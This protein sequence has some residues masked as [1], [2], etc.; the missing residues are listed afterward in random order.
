[1]LLRA[2]ASGSSSPGTSVSRVC[3]QW[4]H[5][6]GRTVQNDCGRTCVLR[7]RDEVSDEGGV[8]D[9]SVT[10]EERLRTVLGRGPTGGQPLPEVCSLAKF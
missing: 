8:R 2:P 4:E 9:R 10:E 3:G 7:T 6:Q 1:M 5:L